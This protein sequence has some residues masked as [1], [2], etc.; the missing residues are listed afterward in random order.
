M[1]ACS[2]MAAGSGSSASSTPTSTN[3]PA[4][5][6]TPERNEVPTM[7]AQ[8][9]AISAGVMATTRQ[10]RLVDGKL[11]PPGSRVRCRGRLGSPRA[12]VK[13]GRGQ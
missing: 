10:W 7:M 12:A 4:I 8:S 1:I 6:N 2:A 9:V 13:P 11:P 5:P 3:P